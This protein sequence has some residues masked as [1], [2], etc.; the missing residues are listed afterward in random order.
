MVEYLLD[1]LDFESMKRQINFYFIPMANA[2]SVKYGTTIANLTGSNLIH[3]W[4]NTNKI[5]QA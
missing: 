4:R 3:D 2:D 1:T 5:Y